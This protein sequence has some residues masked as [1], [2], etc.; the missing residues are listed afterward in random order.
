[1]SENALASA[2]SE[3]T[4]EKNLPLIWDIPTRAFHWLLVLTVGVSLYTGFFGDFEDIDYHMLSGYGVLTLLI[5]RLAWGF[6][7]KGNARFS[8]FTP[9]PATLASHLKG[10]HKPTHNGHNPLG[11]LSVFAMLILLL[12]Q[13]VTGLFAND[14]IF[15][16]GP[17]THLV[18]YEASLELTSIHSINR[19]LLVG[20]VGLHLIAISFYDIVKK[21]GLCI[22]MITGKRST[23]LSL[24]ES[25][26]E[27]EV[28]AESNVIENNTKAS[29]R[30][31]ANTS[32]FAQQQLLLA[33]ILFGLS[34]LLVYV[35]VN[36]I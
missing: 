2:S 11:A 6:L 32:A 3:E 9:S 33:S 27:S 12:L 4:E 18:S 17:L 35:L 13:A 8:R 28:A 19:W 10:Q 14:D 23:G 21:L 29:H 1:M 31:A 7:S 20:L 36:Y 24:Y 22:A 34:A 30:V 15:T 25:E 5:F 16:E 26:V